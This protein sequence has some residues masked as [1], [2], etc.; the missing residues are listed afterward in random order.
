MPVWLW[1]AYK[2]LFTLEPRDWIRFS[3]QNEIKE[4]ANK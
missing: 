1:F 3:V 2:I 4:P